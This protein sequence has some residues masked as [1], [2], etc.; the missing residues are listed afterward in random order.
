MATNHNGFISVRRSHHDQRQQKSQE[1]I[2]WSRG[3]SVGATLFA[4]ISLKIAFSFLFHPLIYLM[5]SS[6]M[7]HADLSELS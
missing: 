5:N 7:P 1:S 6:S 3:E 2:K 4:S